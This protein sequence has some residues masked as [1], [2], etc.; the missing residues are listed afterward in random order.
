MR[1][2][3]RCTESWRTV[4]FYE[5]ANGYSLIR[6][7]VKVRGQVDLIELSRFINLSETGPRLSMFYSA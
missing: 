1:K 3:S 7:T 5:L 4:G 2:R 6:A